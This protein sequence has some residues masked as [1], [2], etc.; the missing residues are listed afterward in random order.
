MNGCNH[1]EPV[2]LCE[3]VEAMALCDGVMVVDGT[4]GRGGHTRRIL[5]A[6]GALGVLLAFD[7]DP[8]AV[9]HAASSFGADRRFSIVHASFEQ[10]AAEAGARGLS[11][12][13]RAVLL[14]LGV[15]ST[16]L[17]D[18][19]RGF[20]FQRGGP[21]DMRMNPDVGVSAGEWLA[22]ANVAELTRVLQ[23]YGEESRAYAIAR[24]IAIRR[25]LLPFTDTL[26]LADLVAKVVSRSESGKHPATR[27]FLALRIQ[28]NDELSSLRRG[29]EAAFSVLAPSGRLVAISFHS[30][31][32]RIVKRFFRLQAGL[33]HLPRRL[34]LSSRQLERARRARLIGKPIRPSSSERARNP[35]ARSA[36]MRVLEKAP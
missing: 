20:S 10:I 35:R 4:Y 7:R 23:Q 36:I 3:A 21:L 24:A 34:P 13:L 32:D 17:L 15:S 14:D 1:H 9:R 12:R 30:L 2:L 33:E 31:E 8:E 25:R 11:G 28:I 19:A 29:L 6:I 18:P 22:G 27:T 5:D 16:Q 26:D